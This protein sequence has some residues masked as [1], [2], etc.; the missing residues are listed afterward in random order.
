MV[1]VPVQPVRQVEHLRGAGLRAEAAAF[2]LFRVRLDQPAIHLSP[3]QHHL[4]K[5][6]DSE[7]IIDPG[8]RIFNGEIYFGLKKATKPRVLVPGSCSGPGMADLTSRDGSAE[9]L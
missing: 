7:F 5:V 2:A 8:N 3:R 9:S 6:L 1:A 4:K